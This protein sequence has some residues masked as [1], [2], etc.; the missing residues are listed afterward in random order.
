MGVK[1]TVA[2]LGVETASL[3]D[4]RFG[5]RVYAPS[6]LLEDYETKARFRVPVDGEGVKLLAQYVG[7]GLL[8]MTIGAEAAAAKGTT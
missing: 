5:D 7:N 2:V 3:L 4:A 8:V 1:V 6:V